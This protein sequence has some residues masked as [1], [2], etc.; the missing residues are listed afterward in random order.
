MAVPQQEEKVGRN[1]LAV[2]VR[3][4]LYI[5]RHRCIISSNSSG[6]KGCVDAVMH[7]SLLGHIIAGMFYMGVDVFGLCY[8]FNRLSHARILTILF[9]LLPPVV[10][11]SA[12][13]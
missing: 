6:D 3:K 13:L 2:H 4:I 10:F 11:A 5:H 8:L 7:S 9:L 12:A 1:D